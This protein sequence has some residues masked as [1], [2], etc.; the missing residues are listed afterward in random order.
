MVPYARRKDKLV[1][2]IMSGWRKTLLYLGMVGLAAVFLY[3]DRETAADNVSQQYRLPK[4]VYVDLSRE[5]YEALRGIP[6]GG[7]KRYTNS[8]GDEYLRQ[9]A[10]S[11]TFMVRTNLQLLKQ[12]E[13]IIQLL[14][15]IRDRE[16]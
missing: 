8:P 9:I 13:R 16:Q 11:S 3:G 1:E 12:Q 6:N 5:F 10:V 15:S 7:E 2:D 4:G 14:E